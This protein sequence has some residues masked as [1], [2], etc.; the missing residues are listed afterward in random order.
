MTR[1]SCKLILVLLACAAPLAAVL[2]NAQPDNGAS[3]G[4]FV[5]PS[6]G[7]QASAAAANRETQTYLDPE[8]PAAKDLSQSAEPP[9]KTTQP[10]PK[11]DALGA[12]E[13]PGPSFAAAGVGERGWIV[14]VAALGLAASLAAAAY[15]A[16]SR[17][18]PD[19]MPVA[20]LM[21]RGL[22]QSSHKPAIVP[23]AEKDVRPERRAA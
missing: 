23:V 8:E 19:S 16:W 12:E 10:R 20:V 6:R 15:V 4:R 13:G 11:I 18:R 9:Q 3:A 7:L 2:V 5:R 14:V 21:P 22:P 17:S 1:N